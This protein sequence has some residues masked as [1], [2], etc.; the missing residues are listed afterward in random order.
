MGL[1]VSA[2]VLILQV[3]PGSPADQAGIKEGDVIVGMDNQDVGGITDLRRL[4]VTHKVGDR[5]PFTVVGASRPR[6]TVEVTLTEG[7]PL[8]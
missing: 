2:G 4:M 6:R 1:P 7:A 3:A 8:A 5:V